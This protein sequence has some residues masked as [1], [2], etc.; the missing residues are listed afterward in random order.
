[1]YQIATYHI[2]ISENF[3]PS[4]LQA[5]CKTGGPQHP[6]L[7]VQRTA[8]QLFQTKVTWPDRIRAMP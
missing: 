2:A 6:L 1:M 3:I 4:A 5:Q 8:R 7:M